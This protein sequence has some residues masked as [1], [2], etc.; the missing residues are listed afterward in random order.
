MVF[1]FF[2]NI[3]LFLSFFLGYFSRD[4]VLLKCF[5]R[6]FFF[7]F[8]CLSG[9]GWYQSGFSQS[10]FLISFWRISF[11]RFLELYDFRQFWWE[12]RALPGG[13]RFRVLLYW[14]SSTCK[15]NYPVKILNK[16][17]IYNILK[18]FNHLLKGHFRENTPKE[19]SDHAWILTTTDLV[20]N[21]RNDHPK[22]CTRKDRSTGH[23]KTP[24]RTQKGGK[25]ISNNGFLAWF[26]A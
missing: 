24:L 16:E 19:V 6:V 4:L 2:F 25:A 13:L 26:Y 9:Y 15:K 22:T 10:F 3:F 14:V 18:F 23:S 12:S 7:F 8:L 1:L 5:F 11:V 20:P 17:I 21:H